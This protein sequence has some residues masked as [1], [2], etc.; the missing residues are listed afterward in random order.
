VLLQGAEAALCPSARRA[1]TL[2]VVGQRYLLLHGGYD[3][4]S[5]LGDTWV[6]NTRRSTWLAVDVQGGLHT[7]QHRPRTALGL[8][9]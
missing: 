5:L 4:C 2:E 6:Y 8:L 7:D 9:L 1:H 3:G